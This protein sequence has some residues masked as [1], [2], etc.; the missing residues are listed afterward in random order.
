[1][2]NL[3]ELR[4]RDFETARILSPEK[5]PPS[6]SCLA[7]R[8]RLLMSVFPTHSVEIQNFSTT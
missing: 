2:L 8:K 4:L 1:M 7:N 3:W 6:M 5:M